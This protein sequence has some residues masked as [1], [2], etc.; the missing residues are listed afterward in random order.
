M[1]GGYWAILLDGE[2]WMACRIREPLE[3]ELTLWQQFDPK[4]A[5]KWASGVV[6]E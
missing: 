3:R 5:S 6:W 4:E 2:L 1:Q